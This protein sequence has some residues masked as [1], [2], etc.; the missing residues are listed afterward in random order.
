MIDL[1]HQQLQPVR[2][3]PEG[4][5][6]GAGGNVALSAAAA[7]GM[8]LAL[9]ELATNAVKYGAL[10]NATGEV[11]LSWSQAGG[12]LTLRWTERGGPAVA[13]P[14]RRGAGLKVLERAFHGAVGGRTLMEWTPEGLGCALEVPLGAG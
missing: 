5:F 8:A 6:A 1:M 4:F 9:H 13:A 10:S 7:Q 11:A 2:R 14:Q 12:L 3:L